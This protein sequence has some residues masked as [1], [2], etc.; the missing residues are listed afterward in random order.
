M[1]NVGFEEDLSRAPL[2]SLP[3][4]KETTTFATLS[5]DTSPSSPRTNSVPSALRSTMFVPKTGRHTTRK[6]Q[7][8][9]CISDGNVWTHQSGCNLQ[10]AVKYGGRNIKTM[11][12]LTKNS[13]YTRHASIDQQNFKIEH[14]CMP[15]Q[16]V[17]RPSSG[18]ESSQEE[19]RLKLDGIRARL[20]ELENALGSICQSQQTLNNSRTSE[21][22][23][24][25]QQIH[26]DTDVTIGQLRNEMK[27]ILSSYLTTPL[28]LD[29]LE[30]GL[31]FLDITER[32][33][34][35]Y[36]NEFRQLI[37]GGEEHLLAELH[38]EARTLPD[39]ITKNKTLTVTLTVLKC[40]SQDIAVVQD[41]LRVHTK[42]VVGI[43]GQPSGP[44]QLTSLRHS[45]ALAEVTNITVSPGGNQLAVVLKV[46]SGTRKFA[47]RLV[48]TV[49]VAYKGR[50][51]TIESNPT[52][53]FISIT[54]DSQYEESKG[55]LFRECVFREE[56][57]IPWALYG[58]A[59][60]AELARA[61]K[62]QLGDPTRLFTLFELDHIHEQ[63]FGRKSLV[64]L[65]D[66]ELFWEWFS[67]FI[68]RMRYQRHI[69]ALWN[70]GAI[71][72]LVSRDDIA[73][74]L[75]STTPGTFALRF[76]EH[77]P[78]LFAVAYKT[79][80]TDATGSV[81]HFLISTE[82]LGTKR[83]IPDVLRKYPEFSQLVR[84]IQGANESHFGVQSKEVALSPY[85]SR[86]EI[87]PTIHDYDTTVEPFAS[88][89]QQQQQQQQQHYPNTFDEFQQLQPPQVDVDPSVFSAPL[90]TTIL[91]TESNERKSVFDD[92][93]A[94]LF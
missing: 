41:S 93:D 59:L 45:Q 8:S 15:I 81:R 4:T 39:T 79:P 57:T 84:V 7:A 73:R 27:K 48:F 38:A 77:N 55:I 17:M 24:R 14:V 28:Q 71:M 33:E 40:A 3:D 49:D 31:A 18:I 82:E 16:G 76:S 69:L 62:Q 30:R 61:T 20:A 29:F 26:S 58:N 90:F 6:R 11:P 78:G 68:Q 86:T 10:G 74:L 35:L 34:R 72:N 1:K 21:E 5:Q 2:T 91:P 75:A 19:L 23:T 85:Y 13:L 52:P 56:K 60:L 46:N 43:S 64:S 94:D 92:D 65:K 42:G 47:T 70:D 83:T 88:Q 53:P 22:I 54:N 51:F 44:Q 87:T 36:G 9:L 66:S 12:V 80:C 32:Q 50:R 89:Q 63:F 25:L 67:K 37:S